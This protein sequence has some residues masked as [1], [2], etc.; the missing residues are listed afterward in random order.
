MVYNAK[1]R[2][3]KQNNSTNVFEV[4]MKLSITLHLKSRIKLNSIKSK[5][6]SHRK[7]NLKKKCFRTNY[8]CIVLWQRQSHENKTKVQYKCQK[9][10]MRKKEQLTQIFTIQNVFLLYLFIYPWSRPFSTCTLL[11]SYFRPMKSATPYITRSRR[12]R[13]NILNTR[14]TKITVT[15]LYC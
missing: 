10:N 8:R 14:K 9:A 12:I 1:K 4:N 13:C 11:N 3:T 7:L 6:F 5:S 2:L 15:F